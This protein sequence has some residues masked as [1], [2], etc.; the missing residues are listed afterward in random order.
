MGSPV[1]YLT[2]PWLFHQKR[3]SQYSLKGLLRG[4][5]ELTLGKGLE[6]C[7]SQ[8]NQ[9]KKEAVGGRLLPTLG[10]S[11]APWIYPRSHHPSR[12]EIFT[13]NSF[14]QILRPS[15]AN[16]WEHQAILWAWLFFLSPTRWASH[17]FLVYLFS[18]ERQNFNNHF[19]SYRRIF[20][21][22]YIVQKSCYLLPQ[23]VI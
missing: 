16:P 7:L 13:S 12:M 11:L 23:H 22:I 15:L 10:R 2:P 3:D 14:L 1:S 17:E 19:I 5:H 21:S 18:S 8:S 6:Q 4:W 9:H 20:T